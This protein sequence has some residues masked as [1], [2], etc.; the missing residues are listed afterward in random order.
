VLDGGPERDEGFV[1]AAGSIVI[2]AIGAYFGLGLAVALTNEAQRSLLIE[3][4]EVSDQFSMLGS[5]VLWIFWPS[6][7]LCV[8]PPEQMPRTAITPFWRCARDV[9]DLQWQ[10]SAGGAGDMAKPPWRAGVASAQ[11]ATRPI[12]YAFVIGSVAAPLRCGLYHHPAR[13]AEAAEKC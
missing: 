6:F 1:D 11:P 5:M 7:V 12:H 9:G 4:N 10:R 2:H 13:V 8:V 3:S